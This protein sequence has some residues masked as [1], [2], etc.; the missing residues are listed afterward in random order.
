MLVGL[1]AK[2]DDCLKSRPATALILA[3]S[4]SERAVLLQRTRADMEAT[5]GSPLED[6]EVDGFENTLRAGTGNRAVADASFD[7][8]FSIAAPRGLPS[9]TLVE[10]YVGLAADCA[11]PFTDVFDPQPNMEWAALRFYVAGWEVCA[12]RDT[13]RHLQGDESAVATAATEAS[14]LDFL[15]ITFSRSDGTANVIKSVDSCRE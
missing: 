4:L 13:A 15:L 12:F 8:S 3:V 9:H 11:A 10:T 5:L 14:S 7:S 2:L 1:R 6:L